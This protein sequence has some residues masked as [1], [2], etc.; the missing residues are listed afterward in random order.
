MVHTFGYASEDVAQIDDLVTW[1]VLGYGHRSPS[2][3]L[4]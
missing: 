2:P 4:S 1:I 3:Q